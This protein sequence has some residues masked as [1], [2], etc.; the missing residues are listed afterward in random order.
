MITVHDT[1][2][3]HQ[4]L[5]YSGICLGT[6]SAD[7]GRVQ[8]WTVIEGVKGEM[9]FI[10]RQHQSTLD[11]E[12]IYHEMFVHGL[13]SGIKTP[14]RVLILGGA[15][16][17]M[18]REVLKWPGVERV[19]QVDWD[20]SLVDFFRVP[21][22]A[23]RWNQGAYSDPRVE[24]HHKD[25]LIWL[26]ETQEQFDAIFIDLLDPADVHDICF[27]KNCISLCKAR[28][29]VNGGLSVNV[30]S[31]VPGVNGP[32]AV[33]A[34]FMATEFT[35]PKFDRL[36]M[37][38]FVPSYL[39]EWC[40]LMAVPRFWS[41]TFAYSVLANDL[42]RF[43]KDEVRFTTQWQKD[44]PDSLRFFWKQQPFYDEERAKK[45]ADENDFLRDK[46]CDH[47]GC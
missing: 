40:F 7:T 30:G 31:V 21:D 32:V 39:G 8:T 16:G 10:D 19:V 14:T 34:D 2:D 13:M 38:T 1:S 35:L 3:P 5:T 26:Q 17:C 42:K 22:V 24:V 45:L 28:L 27:L 43:T 6:N 47:N 11:D 15:E 23:A 44:F 25:A 29:A 4:T 33:L 46:V 18:A 9:L 37:K 41:E 12:Y 36:A 20:K